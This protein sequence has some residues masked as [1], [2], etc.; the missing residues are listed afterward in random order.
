MQRAIK[1]A[2]KMKNIVDNP[3][4]REAKNQNPGIGDIPVG[5]VF[6]HFQKAARE[7]D[8][9]RMKRLRKDIEEMQKEIQK[10]EQPGEQ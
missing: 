4:K 2:E 6:D 7:Q 8:L 10:E 9:E 5:E 1:W 3:E